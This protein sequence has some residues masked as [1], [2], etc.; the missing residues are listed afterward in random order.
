MT[1]IRRVSTALLSLALVAS[2][3]TVV[4][5]SVTPVANAADDPITDTAF[6]YNPV[7]GNFT[8]PGSNVPVAIGTTATVDT[9][10]GQVNFAAPP[11]YL[12]STIYWGDTRVQGSMYDTHIE[13]YYANSTYGASTRVFSYAA[14][15]NGWSSQ[16]YELIDDDYV[17]VLQKSG[18][19][20]H[21]YSGGTAEWN[22]TIRFTVFHEVPLIKVN[23]WLR[24]LNDSSPIG[25]MSINAVMVEGGTGYSYGTD[26]ERHYSYRVDNSG[27]YA[28]GVTNFGLSGAGRGW[29]YENKFCVNRTAHWPMESLC[30]NEMWMLAD[31]LE[32]LDALADKI[33][34]KWWEYTYSPANTNL[35]YVFNSTGGLDLLNWYNDDTFEFVPTSETA[36]VYEN[37][38]IHEYQF[39]ATPI[40]NYRKLPVVQWIDD[41][42]GGNVT[43]VASWSWAINKSLEYDM[44]LTFAATFSDLV[45][46][47]ADCRLWL[48]ALQD[49]TLIEVGDHGYDHAA[50]YGSDGR[51]AW[52]WQYGNV[53]LSQTAWAAYS[54]DPITSWAAPGG[55]WSYQTWDAL[56]AGGI[57]LI[58]LGFL[59]DGGRAFMYNTSNPTA[60]TLVTTAFNQWL[61]WDSTIIESQMR[62]KNGYLQSI[63]HA[64]DC[65]TAG[66]Q[67]LVEACWS[68]VQNQSGILSMT[69]SA[70]YD[71]FN[72]LMRYYTSDGQGVIDL[73]DC[74]ANHEM[75][76]AAEDGRVPILWDIT[77]DQA[78]P[79]GTY[80]ADRGEYEINLARGAEY[81]VV[82][83]I[84]ADYD[85]EFQVTEWAGDDYAFAGAFNGSD[86]TLTVTVVGLG[87]SSYQILV[88]EDV[89]VSLAY[90]DDDGA[91]SYT[92]SDSWSEH[93]IVIQP[94]YV[95]Q[96]TGL[97]TAIFAV[98]IV[99]SIMMT[100]VALVSGSRKKK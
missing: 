69:A 46:A 99:V 4:P 27:Y 63:A 98:I 14:A 53:T 56:G 73:T 96:L 52:G 88:D 13:Y 18:Q 8:D 41:M 59:A 40:Q 79:V 81:Q 83:W 87:S 50:F 25:T 51:E 75:W 58:R 95:A 90:A 2:L 31:D 54:D 29:A 36:T 32:G 68:W 94:S 91:L 49:G 7:T 20:P 38:Q 72:H 17:T 80:H 70:W 76:L 97:A 44:A 3:M 57:R 42:A 33:E 55:T 22:W 47:G 16:W 9:D 21:K 5:S 1:S 6:T 61:D 66:E 62:H 37:G 67:A 39:N 92:Y 100:M 35:A 28:L 11:H 71:Q 82:G 85:V 74:I 26:S 93:T 34:D 12:L 43:S 48:Q 77:H 89:V 65:D 86:G 15:P 60:K 45:A 64:T 30:Y 19:A 84:E 10:W 23:G 24:C 78:A